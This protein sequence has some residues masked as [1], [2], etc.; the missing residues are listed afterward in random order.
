MKLRDI[1]NHQVKQEKTTRTK[2]AR[3]NLKAFRQQKVVHLA[4]NKA[5]ER[6][7]CSRQ[8]Y[9]QADLS[10]PTKKLAGRTVR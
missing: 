1:L 8:A 6:K 4:A 5:E 9:T 7:S 10:K 2:R 3:Q